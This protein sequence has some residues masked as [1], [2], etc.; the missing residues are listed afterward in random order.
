M[1]K[2]AVIP[3]STCCANVQADSQSLHA[4]AV[5]EQAMLPAS[6]LPGGYKQGSLR[7]SLMSRCEMWLQ[8]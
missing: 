7:S 6:L 8:H 1:I 5:D 2:N 4:A 3:S